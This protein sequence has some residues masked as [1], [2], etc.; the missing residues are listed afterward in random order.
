[1]ESDDGRR[2]VSRLTHI[3]TT[4]ET[5]KAQALSSIVVVLLLKVVPNHFVM[6]RVAND[7]FVQTLG[8][9]PVHRIV[10]YPHVSQRKKTLVQSAPAT[11]A[12]IGMSIFSGYIKRV[13]EFT[14]TTAYAS[15]TRTTP[16]LTHFLLLQIATHRGKPIILES[17]NLREYAEKTAESA[18]AE[19]STY[20]I[21]PMKVLVAVKRGSRN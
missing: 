5:P 1:M 7:D 6:G 17:E 11:E 8:C 3:R 10:N 19:K 21:C 2:H 12:T 4:S 14:I 16:H 18:L 13:N 15:T 20:R 9:Q